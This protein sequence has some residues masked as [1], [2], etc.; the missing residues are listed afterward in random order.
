MSDV[1]YLNIVSLPTDLA[2]ESRYCCCDSLNGFGG[3]F[4]RDADARLGSI[5]SYHDLSDTAEAALRTEPMAL[6]KTDHG[7]VRGTLNDDE[8]SRQISPQFIA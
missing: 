8:S 4:V 2:K 7:A 5:R 3:V 1:S 6:S